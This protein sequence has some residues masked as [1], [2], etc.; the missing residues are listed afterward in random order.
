[1]S[2]AQR[3]LFTIFMVDSSHEKEHILKRCKNLLLKCNNLS[4]LSGK[5][6]KRIPAPKTA[7]VHVSMSTAMDFTRINRLIQ[8]GCLERLYFLESLGQFFYN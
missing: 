4:C 7:N 6:L 8:V 2:K 3:V 1:M 5:T